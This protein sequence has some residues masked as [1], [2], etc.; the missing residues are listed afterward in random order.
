MDLVSFV[1]YQNSM[2]SVQK[3]QSG[4]LG[5][6]SQFWGQLLPRNEPMALSHMLGTLQGLSALALRADRLYQAMLD[7]YPENVPLIR[8]YA[9][10]LAD[11]RSMPARAV[12]LY[13]KAD[14]LEDEQAR[15]KQGSLMG[16]GAGDGALVSPDDGLVVANGN[17]IIQLTN[18]ALNKLFG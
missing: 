16:G 3:L 8:L 15:A 18:R 14:S 10:F 7:K 6:M 2:K 12:R 11:V 9:S 13:A 4:A 5:A 1:E 17:G